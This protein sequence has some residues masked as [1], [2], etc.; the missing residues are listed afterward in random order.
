MSSALEKID[1]N[2]S[3]PKT[4]E[5]DDIVFYNVL[6]SPFK[7]HGLIVPKNENEILRR[8]DSDVA[9]K[10]SEGV[11]RLH[12]CTA[13]G[14]VRFITDSPYI[15]IRAAMSNIHKIPHMPLTGTAGFDMYFRE[16]DKEIYKGTFNPPFDIETG[17]ESVINCENGE[18]TVTINLPLYSNVDALFIGLKENSTLKSAPDYKYNNPI[19][20][21]GSSIT[22]GGCST[23]PGNTYEG[24]ISRELD[25]DYINL[26]FAGNAKGEKEISEYIRN[27]DMSIFVYDYDHN[28]PTPKHLQE[29]HERMFKEFREVNPHTPV[30]MLSRPKFYLTKEEEERARIV[31]QT[32]ENALKQGDKNVYHIYGKDLLTGLAQ[33]D[34]TVDNTHPTDLGFASMAEKLCVIIK[35]LLNN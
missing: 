24:I 15:A 9:K 17:Y 35:S 1:K 28:A 23:R 26:G 4:I 29:T 16:G 18:K 21:Y 22:H 20:Y 30:I 7:I 10:V 31:R 13:G 25:C 14:R 3:I 5:K 6:S 27:L 12:T 8:M 32:Y 19:V 33:I 34:G 11:D 2:F